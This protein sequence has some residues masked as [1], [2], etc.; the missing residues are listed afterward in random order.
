MNSF[1]FDQ[2][3]ERLTEDHSE[4]NSNMLYAFPQITV[5]LGNCWYNSIQ[6]HKFIWLQSNMLEKKDNNLNQYP[7]LNVISRISKYNQSDLQLNC[8]FSFRLPP[9]EKNHPSRV[10]H[11]P[12]SPFYNDSIMKHS[13]RHHHFIKRLCSVSLRKWFALIPHLTSSRLELLHYLDFFNESDF[14]SFDNNLF[15]PLKHLLILF[16]FSPFSV[17]RL[18]VDL[19]STGFHGFQNLST[20]GWMN[21]CQIKRRNGSKTQGTQTIFLRN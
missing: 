16:S 11:P 13:N 9:P 2:A 10:E 19:S 15:L 5:A 4:S 20:I 18:F 21:L 1:A 17:V 3:G 8:Y 7:L 6:L 12:L 14:T